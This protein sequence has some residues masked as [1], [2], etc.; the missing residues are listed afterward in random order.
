MEGQEG[1]RRMTVLELIRQ[2]RKNIAAAGAELDAAVD[3]M[4]VVLIPRLHQLG[5]YRLKELKRALKRYDAHKGVWK[6]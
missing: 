5:G 4:A 2:H 6:S 1:A 3:E